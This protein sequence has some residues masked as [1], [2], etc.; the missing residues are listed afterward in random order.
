MD[1]DVDVLAPPFRFLD[2]EAGALRQ[3]SFPP[4][5]TPC[6]VSQ[7]TWDSDPFVIPLKSHR[8]KHGRCFYLAISWGFGDAFELQ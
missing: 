7:Q 4:F 8:S 1:V 3:I 6:G 2:K 5:Q